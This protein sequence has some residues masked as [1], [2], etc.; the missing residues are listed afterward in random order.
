MNELVALYASPAA[1]RMYDEEVTELEHALQSAALAQAEGA[2]DHLVAAALLHDMGQF[3]SFKGHHKHSLYLI[4]NTELPNFGD[5][6]MLLVGNVARYH[7]KAHPQD[8]HHFFTILDEGERSRV[9]RLA[10]LLR[11]ADALDREHRQR[12]TGV[13][14]KVTDDEVALWLDGTAGALLEGFTVQKKANLFQQTFD[15]TVSLRFLGEHQD[16]AGP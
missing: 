4:C 13:T 3:V 11:V 6:E 14:A 10:A 12:V 15:R 7:R 5:R 9:T 2:P 8:H 1:R 16:A